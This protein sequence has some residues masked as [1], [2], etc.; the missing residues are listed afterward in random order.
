MA[1]PQFNLKTGADSQLYYG[2][3]ITEVGADKDKL[4]S[5][6]GAYEYPCLARQTGN[7]IKGST[8]SIDS[9]ELRKGRARSAP[10]KGNSSADGS[11]E[12]E[13]SPITFDDLM[14]AALRG[15]WTL[16][17]GDL[18]STNKA[19]KEAIKKSQTLVFTNGDYCM[20]TKCAGTIDTTKAVGFGRKKMFRFFGDKV[21]TDNGWDESMKKWDFTKDATHGLFEI[22]AG[23]IIHELNTGTKDIKYM[24]LRQF[25]G[26]EGEDLF[27]KFDHMAVST[28]SN[29][30]SIGSIITGS[31]GFMGANDP[32]MLDTLNTK[33]QFGAYDFSGSGAPGANSDAKKEDVYFDTTNK[34]FYVA[35]KDQPAADTDWEDQTDVFAKPEAIFKEAVKADNFMKLPETATQ[36]DQFTAREGF[37]YLNGRNIEFANAMDW[38]LDNG[39]EKN[40]AI[41]VRNSISTT[42][43]TLDIQ[44]NLSTY[45][46]HGYSDKIFN[47]A[48]DDEDNELLWCI[49]DNEDNPKY[50]YIFQIFKSKFTD[51][52]AGVGGPDTITN[53]YP[54]QSFGEQTMRIFR[55]TLPEATVSASKTNGVSV[56]FGVCVPSTEATKFVVKAYKTDAGPTEIELP[57]VQVSDLND[58]EIKLAFTDSDAVSVGEKINI[59]VEYQ[60]ATGDASSKGVIA[61]VTAMVA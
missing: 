61:D 38:N 5:K 45:L 51:H 48:V 12:Y 40:Y 58:N 41:F 53:S 6:D 8:E 3:E 30:I 52:D 15:E 43:L 60:T 9:N 59:K 21:I 49:E 35:K 27:Q 31:V 22:P 1:D 17:N 24:I 28:I 32:K 11:M 23:S 14:E 55:V 57:A 19:L 13:L 29:D 2:R 18:N 54:F 56:K 50:L 10:R 33:K 47:E 39:L 25:G 44:G 46:I 34:K 42:P 37:L 4:K 26:V 36:T 7:S 16:W 20:A